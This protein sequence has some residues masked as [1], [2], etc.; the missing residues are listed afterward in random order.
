MS[1]LEL[2]QIKK[3]ILNDEYYEK[4]RDIISIQHKQY[5]QLNAEYIS[6]KKS[7]YYLKHKSAYKERYKLQ[8]KNQFNQ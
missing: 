1:Q 4:H 6:A 3:K 8:K 7:L 2:N 5:R